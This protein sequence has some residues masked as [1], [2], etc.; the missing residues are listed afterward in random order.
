MANEKEGQKVALSL[1]VMLIANCHPFHLGNKWFLNR[2]E[3]G[4]G[5]LERYRKSGVALRVVL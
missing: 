3:W 5:W 1:V 4:G 2:R